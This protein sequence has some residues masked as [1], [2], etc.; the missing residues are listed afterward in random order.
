M[1][2]VTLD[3]GMEMLNGQMFNYNDPDVSSID[4]QLVADVLSR[5]CRFAGHVKHFY[6]IAQHAVNVSL[7]VAL[8]HEKEA[9]LHDTSEF[10]TNDMVTPLKAMMP[11]FRVV[12]HRIESRLCAHFGVPHPMSPAVKLADLQMLRIERAHLRPNDRS[13]WKHLEGVPVSSFEQLAIMD[14]LSPREASDLFMK[15]WEL[16]A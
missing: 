1:H 5:N 6:S 11:D 2:A 10:V 3:M 16:V 14:E 8:G 13:T 7:I 9:L 12:E 4:I 15:R